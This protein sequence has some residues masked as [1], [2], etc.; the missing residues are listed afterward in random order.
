MREGNEEFYMETGM[1]MRSAGVKVDLLPPGQTFVPTPT[2]VPTPPPVKEKVQS[3]LAGAAVLAADE[4]QQE[5]APPLRT[6]LMTYPNNEMHNVDPSL[7]KEHLANS[8]LIG[9]LVIADVLEEK[10]MQR[11]NTYYLTRNNEGIV[12]EGGSVFA[13]ESCSIEIPPENLLLR[14]QG[15][16]EGKAFQPLWQFAEDRD[17]AVRHTTATLVTLYETSNYQLFAVLVADSDPASPDYFNYGSHPTFDSD[18]AMMAYVQS[19][20]A[21]S[22]YDFGLDVVP[23]DR[24]LTLATVDDGNKV[25]LVYR[26]DR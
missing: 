20:R 5:E 22:I 15:K 12:S 23:S 10:V 26:Q 14:G 24:L 1:D 16:V 2:P 17:F 6:R 11:N 25:V 9:R 21:H 3:V 7:A 8:D 19:L 18:E 13:D 4:E